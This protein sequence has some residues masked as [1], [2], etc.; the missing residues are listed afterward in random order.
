MTA[1]NNSNNHSD[2]TPE[3]QIMS[4][5]QV[6]E[7]INFLMSCMDDIAIIMT[8]GL[9][10]VKNY[11]NI[12]EIEGDYFI[13]SCCKA[14]N[15]RI[16]N[17][18]FERIKPILN[19]HEKFL[20]ENFEKKNDIKRNLA[21]LKIVA[22]M[23]PL[24]IGLKKRMKIPDMNNLLPMMTGDDVHTERELPPL[25]IGA[26]F[27]TKRFSNYAEEHNK[28][29]NLHGGIQFELETCSIKQNCYE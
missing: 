24:L 26:D 23:T 16:N 13:N 29:F 9:K 4:D 11:K 12:Y 18:K 5:E 28:Y 19:M 21:I 3:S 17:K 27:K 6:K 14:D 2:H 22:F 8:L 1:N 15:D 20:R 10:S 7:D 25:M